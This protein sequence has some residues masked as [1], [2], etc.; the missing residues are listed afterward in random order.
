M[1]PALEGRNRQRH[2]LDER[3]EA[4]LCG[5]R[6]P[7]A[8]VERGRAGEERRRVAVRP[9]A[10]QHEVERLILEGG[11]VGGGS[12]GRRERGRDRMHR[13]PDHE[14]LEQGLA[15]EQLV[16]AGIVGGDAAVVAEPDLD[17]APVGVRRGRELVGVPGRGAPCQDHRAVRLGDVHEQRGRRD[18]RRDCVGN[19][20]EVDVHRPILPHRRPLGRAR[21][22]GRRRERALPQLLT[23]DLKRAISQV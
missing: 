8:H 10:E 18:G 7:V 13:R 6:E 20:D 23:L 9:E 1:G 3:L 2:P 4:G 22:V 17:A 21:G 11:V 16:R 14:P 12:V 5:D 19:H 15:D